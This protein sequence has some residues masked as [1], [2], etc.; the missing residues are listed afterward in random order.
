M[1]TIG[2]NS[3]PPSL[4]ALSLGQVALK[5]LAG[6]SPRGTETRVSLRFI[7]WALLVCRLCPRHCGSVENKENQIQ[8]DA[9]CLSKRRST[10]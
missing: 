8:E 3:A 4:A 10:G 7:P 1:D 6:P 9:Q 5:S 2:L